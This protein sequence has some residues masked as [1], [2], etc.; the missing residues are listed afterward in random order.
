MN[1]IQEYGGSSDD[2]ES[3]SEKNSDAPAH[4]KPLPGG[5]SIA[6]KL[7]ALSA[8]PEVVPMVCGV[9]FQMLHSAEC[10]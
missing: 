3:D 4:D 10:K 9:L 1:A 2:G 6:A 7:L 5:S 8:A